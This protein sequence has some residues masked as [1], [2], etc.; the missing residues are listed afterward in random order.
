VSGPT[1]L[2]GDV[3]QQLRLELKVYG[4]VSESVAL[5]VRRGQ[6]EV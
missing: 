5:T 3:F 4:A 2:R 6:E 1:F